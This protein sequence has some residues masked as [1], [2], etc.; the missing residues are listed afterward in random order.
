MNG[1]SRFSSSLLAT[2]RTRLV[3]P[4]LPGACNITGCPESALLLFPDCEVLFPGDQT[5]AHKRILLRF[6]KRTVALVEAQNH[7]GKGE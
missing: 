2:T 4:Y 6:H 7:E 1:I 5:S 3:L